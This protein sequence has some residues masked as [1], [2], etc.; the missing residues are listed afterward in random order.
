MAYWTQQDV[1]SR[2]SNVL[3]Q[4]LSFTT[5]I[6]HKANVSAPSSPIVYGCFKNQDK[7]PLGK[8]NWK[9]EDVLFNL[10]DWCMNREHL[11]VP[12]MWKLLDHIENNLMSLFCIHYHPTRRYHT[13]IKYL[14]YS[15]FLS[16]FVLSYPD[17]P[18][19][20]CAA[21]GANTAQATGFTFL[22]TALP[23]LPCKWLYWQEGVIHW[24]PARLDPSL[25]SVSATTEHNRNFT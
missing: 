14:K 23:W 19:F 10:S 13:Y 18:C 6:S 4:C 24:A 11:Y 16:E 22:F 21:A 7:W 25:R 8:R 17:S 1:M 5:N 12:Q 9:T 15:Y 2:K 20:G 3:S